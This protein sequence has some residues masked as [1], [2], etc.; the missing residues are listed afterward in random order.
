[1]TIAQDIQKLD[2]G[3]EVKLF[4]LDTTMFV[5]GSVNRFHDGSNEFNGDVLW[6]GN[7]YQQWPIQVTGFEKTSEGT[8]ARPRV[9]VANVLGTF[10][11][12]NLLFDDMVGAQL[13]RITTF[14]KYLDAANFVSGNPDAD[15][16]QKMPDEVYFVHRKTSEN[17]NFVEYELA[18]PWDVQGITLPRRKIVSN[19]CTWGYRSAECSYAGGAVA[20]ADDTPT[21]DPLLDVCGKRSTSCELRFG[22]G[23]ELPFG[24]FPGANL[25]R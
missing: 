9:K 10:Y 21:S 18:A 19:I 14:I 22:V 6:D 2:A 23:N 1:M 25:V 11:N 17:K 15:P 24:G 4:E 12:L 13:S 16:T 8:L 20:K 3:A 7:A 5:G